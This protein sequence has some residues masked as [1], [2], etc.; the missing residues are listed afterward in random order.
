MTTPRSRR[1]GATPPAPETDLPAELLAENPQPAREALV[2]TLRARADSVQPPTP[3]VGVPSA[4]GGAPR[5]DA[6]A[7]ADTPAFE[8]GSFGVRSIDQHDALFRAA[9]DAVFRKKGVRVNPRFMKAVMGGESGDNGDYPVSRC[10]PYDGYPGPRSCGPMQIKYDFHKQRCPECDNTTLAGHIELAT[11]IIGD[12]MR[13]HR[14]DEYEAYIRGYLTSDDINGT[15]QQAAVAKL[16]QRVATMEADAGVAPDDPWRPYPYP[17]MVDLI[18]PKP[19]DSAGFDRVAFR[20]PQ[21]QGF[22]THITDGPQSQPIEFFRDFFGTGGERARDAL[23]DL[24]IGADGRIGLLNDWRDPQRGGTRAGWANGWGDDGPGFERGGDAWYRRF[25]NLNVSLVSAEHA[26]KAGQQ[27][28]DPMMESSIE[29]RTAVAQELKIPAASYPINP[30]H[31]MSIERQ[32][33]D[34]AKKSCPAEAYIST[35]EPVIMREVQQKLAAWQGGNVPIPEPEPAITYTSW[36]LSPEMVADFFGVMQ[37]HNPNGT[38]DDLAFNPEGPLSLLWLS[39]AEKEGKF[40]EAESLKIFDAAWHPG[41]EWYATWEGGWVAV[42]PVGDT[43]ASWRWLDE[44]E[45]GK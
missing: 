1:K 9:S 13:A 40:P 20:R 34:F 38:V 41:Q 43:R 18:V 5:T 19:Y 35:H 8:L 2:S 32:H 42:L 30:L 7:S 23:T 21:I 15:T 6:G 39:R 16:R 22:C 33:R 11:H 24:V 26:S 4:S 3:T 45:V 10:R 44:I 17:K 31:G 12:T 27:W 29:V 28:T 37:R 25:P 36:G 14:C